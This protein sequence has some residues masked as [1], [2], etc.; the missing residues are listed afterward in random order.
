[1]IRQAA[2]AL[3]ISIPTITHAQLDSQFVFNGQNA[4]ILTAQKAVT[5]ITPEQKEVPDT[6]T[7]QVPTGQIEVCDD[8]T[9]YREECTYVPSSESCGYESERV[10]HP[11]S[12]SR[13]VCSGGGSH[14]ECTTIPSSTVCT[15]R[16]T[17]EVCHTNPHNGE[18]SCTTVGG[19]QS[20]HDVGGGQSCTTVQDSPNCHTEY[21]S[22]EECSNDSRYVCHTNPGHNDCHSVPYSEEV[23]GMETQYRTE[24]YACTRTITVNKEEKKTVKAETNIQ[25][26]TNGLV[27]EIPMLVSIKEVNTQFKAFTIN[28]KLEKEPKLFVVMKSK[29]VKVVSANAKEVI[30]KA[31]LVLEVMTKDMLPIKLPTAISSASIDANKKLVIAF[32]GA[33]AAKGKLDLS[34]EH[35]VLFGHKVDAVLKSDYPVAR[36]IEVGI[37][38]GKPALSIDLRNA[39][40]KKPVKGMKLKLELEAALDLKGEL[41]NAAKPEMK[42]SFQSVQIILK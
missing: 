17:R 5:V 39:M 36:S 3:L 35:K 4:E 30:V 6:C 25:I 32:E 19:G 37:S 26:N 23:C 33:L 15:E 20:C 42:K 29:E 24:S 18:S 38:E 21:Y 10:C 14:Q 9:R 22:D 41:L 27:D 34:I 13:E 2:L 40:V 31:T 8:V 28:V 1:M 12:R 11:V 7:R 16:P